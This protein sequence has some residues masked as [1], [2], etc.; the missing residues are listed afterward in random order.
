MKKILV[1]DDELPALTNIQLALQAHRDWQLVASCHSTAQAR[2][3]LQTE[4]VDLILLD[5]E[6]PM[7][8]GLEFAR[9]L[10]AQPNPPLI[11]FITAYNKHA[12]AAF[13]VFALDYLLKPFE[14]ERFAIMLER[15]SLIIEKNQQVAQ[16]AAMQDYFRDQDALNAGEKAPLLNHIVVR[17]MG[18]IE[19]IGVHEIIWLSAA[20][21]YV[22]LH[23][24]DRIL[25]HRSTITFM[26]EHLPADLF[27]RLHRNSIVRCDA[28]RSIGV[29]S[30]YG[31]FTALSNGDKVSIS[32]RNFK[33]AKKLLG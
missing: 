33:R 14:D 20:G 23:L 6:M 18:H 22:E 7:Q 13:E 17:S 27:A 11:V 1:V 3:L 2:A 19:R 29:D 32:V 30:E 8:S 12:V 28:M 10:S 26:E 16:I 15:A 4:Q 21:N 5:I 31:Y 25:L 9:E 24:R